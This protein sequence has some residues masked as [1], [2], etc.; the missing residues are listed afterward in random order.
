MAINILC[1]QLVVEGRLKRQ[2]C[3]KMEREGK[4]LRCAIKIYMF[5]TSR[6]H[7]LYLHVAY[8]EVEGKGER[9]MRG[10]FFFFCIFY[11]LCE[12]LP[13]CLIRPKRKT[14]MNK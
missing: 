12:L 14:V 6:K 4:K 7:I 5:G 8:R 10:F 13:R 1:A 2:F 9:L 3:L 11:H